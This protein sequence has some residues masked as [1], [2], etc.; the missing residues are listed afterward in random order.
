MNKGV[1]R[2]SRTS[3]GTKGG[4]EER[5]RGCPKNPNGEERM[6]HEPEGGKLG[7]GSWGNFKCQNKG[8]VRGG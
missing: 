5:R 4:G 7:V 8:G 6:P 1:R 3:Q 2:R